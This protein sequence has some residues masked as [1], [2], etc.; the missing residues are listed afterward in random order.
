MNRLN[1]WI[2]LDDKSAR[3]LNVP[4]GVDNTHEV[5][6]AGDLVAVV[7]F[8]IPQPYGRVFEKVPVFADQC[9]RRVEYPDRPMRR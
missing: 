6:G 3:L 9:A 5:D 8:K 7:V 4:D 2:H 1:S